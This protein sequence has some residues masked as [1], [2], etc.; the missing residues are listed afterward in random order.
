MAT[1]S[2]SGLFGVGGFYSDD[3]VNHPINYTTVTYNHTL[4]FSYSQT[5][6]TL[7][8]KYYSWCVSENPDPETEP[9]EYEKYVDGTCAGSIDTVIN[10]SGNS[11]KRSLNE[12]DTVE[13]TVGQLVLL[14][15]C[16]SCDRSGGGTLAA[17]YTG[18]PVY[19]T[20]SDVEYTSNQD[21]CDAAGM[22]DPNA[23]CDPAYRNPGFPEEE[24]NPSASCP[25]YLAG[26]SESGNAD[27][28][29]SYTGFCVETDEAG[30]INA[31]DIPGFVGEPFTNYVVYFVSKP[32]FLHPAVT[33][34]PNTTDYDVA[35]EAGNS[36]FSVVDFASVT[37]TGIAV[38][39]PATLPSHFTYS[40]SRFYTQDTYEPTGPTEGCEANGV[41]TD[42]TF[43]AAEQISMTFSFS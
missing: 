26:G 32:F 15:P 36:I 9:P 14:T 18:N 20:T 38:Y 25:Y 8:K 13:S 28:D 23:F 40:C 22:I 33:E 7:T 10:W 31:Y 11:Q 17:A 4:N 6:R 12:F 16:C 30:L 21:P 37:K 41:I 19:T 27:V 3:L 5:T 39:A 2:G 35:F 29:V 42:Y 43:E 1:C 24:V 34:I